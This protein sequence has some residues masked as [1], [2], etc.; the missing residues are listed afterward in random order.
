MLIKK[1]NIK[2]ELPIEVLWS[3]ISD[4]KRFKWLILRI[5]KVYGFSKSI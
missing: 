4:L 2:V 1:G 3:L 5:M